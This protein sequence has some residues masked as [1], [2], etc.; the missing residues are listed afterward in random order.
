M[1]VFVGA[2]ATATI[3]VAATAAQAQ[4]RELVELPMRVGGAVIHTVSDFGGPGPYA[5]MPPAYDVPPPS[6]AYVA[7]GG[8][9]APAVL[10][11]REIYAILREAG[12]SPLGMP[13]Q[14]GLVYTVSALD[15]DGED[16]RMVIDARSGR[17][18]RFMPAYRMGS[19]MDDETMSSYGPEGGLPPAPYIRREPH[20]SG[21]APKVASRTTSVPLPKRA[22]ARAVAAPVT[23]VA[24]VETK[25]VAVVPPATPP[26]A[27]PVQQSAVT[28]P[29]VIEAKPV[30]T[31]G[32][33]PA[34]APDAAAA[35][36]TVPAAP[37]EAKPATP[38]KPAD[39]PPAVQELE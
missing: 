27:A 17:I 35:A 11:P 32:T 31:T 29:K 4:V 38:D 19:R 39:A 6:Y 10:P 26:D 20:A 15:Q 28:E 2:L 3:L 16:G 8:Y 25:P 14:R 23:P 18:L 30:E 21:P 33:A 12:F 22:P 34:K 13:Q 9:G 1:K 24:P 37:V 5:A 36:P 7:P